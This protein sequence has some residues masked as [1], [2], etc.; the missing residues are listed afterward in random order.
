MLH[1]RGDKRGKGY[2]TALL[3]RTI[4]ELIATNVDEISTSVR[5]TN[6]EAQKLYKRIGF[7]DK[8]T[9]YAYKKYLD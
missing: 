7:V 5:V 3:K 2:G 4:G 8:E 9:I 1:V 6:Y